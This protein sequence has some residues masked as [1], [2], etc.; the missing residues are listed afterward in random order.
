MNPPAENKPLDPQPLLLTLQSSLVDTIENDERERD[1]IDERIEANRALLSAINVSLGAAVNK[2]T[3]GGRRERARIMERHTN[4]RRLE[5]RTRLQPRPL[6]NGGYH[7]VQQG[8]ANQPF[9]S[10]IGALLAPIV[11]KIDTAVN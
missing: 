6:P 8:T 11:V 10:C 7:P 9:T 5:Q 4:S 3:G 1:L 2:A